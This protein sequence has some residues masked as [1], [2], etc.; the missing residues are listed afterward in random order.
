[1]KKLLIANRGEIAIRIARTAAEMG[2]ATVAVFA[3]DDATSLHTRR[4][5]EAV[6][7]KGSGARAYLDIAQIVGV[8]RASGC[9]AVHPGY[10]FL[11]ENAAFAQ[12]CAD[13]GVT[14]VGP[15][16]AT[17]ALF[18]D[19][20]AALG[21]ASR[22]DI[23][24]LPGS[25][26]R[27][28][29]EEAD[30]FMASL[31]DGGAVMLKAL[32]GGGGRGMRP[33]S[34]RADL[35]EAFERCASE[36]K[37]AFGDGGLYAEQLFPRARHVEVQILGEGTGAVV[38]LWDREC[39]LQR[40]RQKLVEIAP[41]VGVDD[42]VR[43]A[44]RAAAVKMAYAAGY[45]GLGTIEFLVNENEGE[46][47]FAFIEANPRLQVEHTVTEQVTGLDLVRLQL[48]IAGGA[49][50]AS[51][52]LGQ[53]SAVPAAYGVS[54]Q[55]RVNLE[56]MT[57]DGQVRPTGGVLETYEPPSGAGVRV[58]GF[59]YAGYRTSVRYD[60]LLAK[61]IVHAD[62]L[63]TAAAKSRRA[64]GE[65]HLT[66]TASNIPFLQALMHRLE[67]GETAIHTRYVEQHIGELT[68]EAAAEAEAAAK[69]AVAAAAEAPA[70]ADDLV[71]TEPVA[72]PAVEVAIAAAAEVAAATIAEPE[73]EIAIGAAPEPVAEP[74][75][76]V[77]IAPALE[78]VAEAAAE[79]AP[80][81]APERPVAPELQRRA[82]AKI[83]AIDP[84]AVLAHGKSN[85]GPV[86]VAAPAPQAAVL[87][88]IVGPEGTT[89]LRAPLQGTIV[90]LAAQPGDAV[91]AG[92][93][94]A[95]M[96]SMKMEHVIVAHIS[97]YVREFTVEAGDTVFEDH[98]LAFLE[99]ADIG[100]AG[101]GEAEEV[102]LDYIRPD[103]A[104]VLERHAKTL[105]AARPDAVARRRKTGQRTTRENVDDLLDPGS[106][107]E[108][109]ALTVAARRR[110]HSLEELIDQTPADGLV[111][112][113]GRV[114]GALVGEEAARC[115]VMAYDYTVLAG[116]QGAYNHAKMDRVIE[117]AERWMLP[118][119]FFCEG[120][121]GRPGDTEGG[122]GG[123]TRGF[124]TW[125]KMSALAPTVGI[126][127]G[128]CFA[129]N[130]SVLGCCD[131]IIA[132][133]GSNIGMGGPAMI[134]GGGLGVFR[135][136]DIGPVEVQ[137][138]NGVIDIL[139]ED[140]AAAVAVTKQY[141][142]YFQGPVQGWSC[143]DQ[144]QLRRVI[145]ENR[146]RVYDIR[147]LI[148]TLADEGS[149]LEI[150]PKFGTTMI[151]ALI[152]IEGRP[153][154]VIANNPKVLG[155]AIDS[156]GSDKAA[157]FMQ[158]CEAYDVPIL[159]LSDTPGMMVG[160]EIEKTALVR[161][162]SRLF[163]IGAN[164]TV[165]LLSVFLRKS[166]G[167]GAL[168]MTGGS[169]QKSAFAVAWPTG[170]FGGMGLEGSVKLGY[171]NELAAIAD[172]AER[173]AKFDQMVAQA[174]ESGKA[175]NRATSFFIDDV[176]DPADTRRWIMGA[177]N[178]LPPT[179]KRTG[180]KLRWIDAW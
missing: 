83:D 78:P 84:L 113:L 51:L 177:L 144:R 142:S 175:L 154:G 5:D 98:P 180:K 91:R 54:I 17:L 145:P 76:E 117:L 159:S 8:A 66:G 79:A 20:T 70:A 59:G 46:P 3:E 50:L 170:E 32:A 81:P 123:G 19:K 127:S 62:S 166:Y 53:Q 16:P 158:I 106:F 165:P 138:P 56:T 103:L 96:E 172:P 140:E 82:G 33:V 48:E 44:L 169:Y 67:A 86:T 1:M 104:L 60:S 31:G 10:G 30:A 35:A 87:A 58:D 102:D 126:T 25:R 133:K 131:V 114:N 164:L 119:V 100:E 167:L 43:S 92:Q 176:I 110:R 153:M 168:A 45:K 134:E 143:A 73:A 150:R 107:V 12:D 23:P 124:E 72:T 39:S 47:R 155:G 64:L 121:G 152:R 80:E 15:A 52:G 18:G 151:T 147:E 61:V 95:I 115:A 132:T 139:V 163:I 34:R 178:S 156:D 93:P 101:A 173:R 65:F 130:A 55:A 157:R 42:A 148:Q 75:A 11:S 37:A 125:G 120:G 63:Q 141:L 89:A 146:L 74:A 116:T 94:V 111:M 21:L 2:I 49:T 160:P 41:A 99:E 161:H 22:L 171:R 40:Q 179:P 149:V 9:D 71:L 97:G 174:Y 4:T 88:D 105:D 28:S 13:A 85:A 7:L 6:A 162:C 27:T 129:G 29:L 122:G 57:A 68:A 24:T 38:H 108:Y 77:A 36:A 90:S 109:G 128:R 135:P 14:F 26:G 112:G 137:E 136:E 69:A 118:T